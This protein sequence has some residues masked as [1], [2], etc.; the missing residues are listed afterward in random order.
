MSTIESETSLPMAFINPRPFQA[1]IR[2][3]FTANQLSQFMDQQ[4]I[5][6]E[7][8]NMRTL[9]ALGP[10]GLT[11]ERAGFEVRDVHPSHYG[12]LCP[13]HTPEGQNIGLIL[14]LALH[15]RT[16][17]FGVIET[18]YVSREE[19]E[20]DGGRSSIST[21]LKKRNIR[22][23]TA[24]RRRNKENRLLSETVEA[25]RNGEASSGLSRR[26]RAHGRFYLSDVLRRDRNDSIC[27]IM[28]T[29]T[30]HSWVRTCRSRR[31]LSSFL[32]RHSSRQ[33]SK[34]TQHATL[35]AS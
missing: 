11:R 33:A 4:N 15:A 35:V 6:A 9:S 31:R 17:E 1:S 27:S 30:V 29:R 21:H 10:G 34:S 32:R 24:Q 26:S 5:L 23:H 25:R 19:R 3:F 22:L 8:E 18:P 28:T 12:R 7:L 14:R 20:G 2:E 16:N 13:I